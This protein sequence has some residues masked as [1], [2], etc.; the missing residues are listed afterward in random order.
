MHWY[1]YAFLK[2]IWK[3]NF[4]ETWDDWRAF[5]GLDREEYDGD[6]MNFERWRQ[7]LKSQSIEADISLLWLAWRPTS[8]PFGCTAAFP[9]WPGILKGHIWTN[10]T[11]GLE[12]KPWVSFRTCRCFPDEKGEKMVALSW[13]G[14]VTLWSQGESHQRKERELTGGKQQWIASQIWLI[15]T[16][17]TAYSHSPFHMH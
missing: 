1:K 8:L 2:G 16:T 5:L 3:G 15:S 14:F 10:Q 12:N 9:A 11:E 4:W 13:Q 7:C 6:V 17:Y